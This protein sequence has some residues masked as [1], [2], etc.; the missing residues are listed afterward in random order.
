[1]V[2]LYCPKQNE[3]LNNNAQKLVAVLTNKFAK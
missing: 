1:M 3:K 2:I